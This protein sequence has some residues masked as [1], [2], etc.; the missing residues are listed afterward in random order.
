MDSM[1]MLWIAIWTLIRTGV[2]KFIGSE[3][4]QEAVL[5]DQDYR[6]M[7]GQ[8]K[9]YW[10]KLFTKPITVTSK[11]GKTMVI[12]PQRTNNLMERF[13]RELNRGSRRRTGGKTLGKVLATMLAETPLVKN[14]EN[15]KYEKIILSGCSGLPERFAEIEASLVREKMKQATQE[16][17]RLPSVVKCLIRMPKLPDHVIGV[18]VLP[19]VP[20]ETSANFEI[21]TPLASCKS[22]PSDGVA[23]LMDNAGVWIPVGTQLDQAVCF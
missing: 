12:Q 21:G 8:I 11:N 17:E 1:T 2:E 19:T 18:W 6:K 15:A 22:E 3:E 7:V 23:H 13:F 9:K 10:D 5:C 16:A 14:L 4:I 20:G